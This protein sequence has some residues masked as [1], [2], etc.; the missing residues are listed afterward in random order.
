M[1]T[2]LNK[3][4]SIENQI[5]EKAFLEFNST[6]ATRALSLFLVQ[7]DNNYAIGSDGLIYRIGRINENCTPTLVYK[8]ENGTIYNYAN[9]S[10]D[11]EGDS[12]DLEI[13]SHCQIQAE[14]MAEHD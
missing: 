14:L 4:I 7:F 12:E 5:R 2:I 9:D 11:F 13:F 10:A 8:S 3:D 6:A 1:H